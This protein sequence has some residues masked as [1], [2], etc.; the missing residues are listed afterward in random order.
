MN[1]TGPHSRVLIVGGGIGGLTTGIALARNGLGA[2]LLERS[3]FAD[4]TGAGIQLGPNATRALA[5]LGVLDA[6]ERVAFKPESLRLFD[7][8]TGSALA[9]MPLGRVVEDRHGAPY[10]TF[11]RADLHAALLNACRAGG[12]D[13]R[14]GLEVV[15]VESRVDGVTA[16]GAN[17]TT[18]EAACLVAA[19][20]LWSRLRA[21][22]APH[23]ELRFAGATAWRALLPRDGLPAPF[24]AAAV[25]LWLG[26]RAHLVHY[27][28][29]G[30]KELN[31]VAVVEGGSAE[32]G[33]NLRA[34][35]D[36]LAAAFN[37]WADPVKAVLAGVPAWR[38]WSLFRQTPLRS[39]TR[40]RMALL[41]D[42]AHPVLPYLAQGAALAIEDAVTVAACLKTEDPAS[43]FARYEAL[44]LHRAAR[45]QSQAARLGRLYHLGGF[46]A[47]T[48]NLILKQRRGEALL[49]GFDWLY[50]RQ[51]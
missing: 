6:V 43:A 39:W 26:P 36:A 51:A 40:G 2:T 5:G 27:P 23:A 15:D 41:G 50:G 45:V 10:L 48:R 46:A 18:I 3:A 12:V 9:V 8:A 30:G 14:D 47:V 16:R 22:I 31:L 32:Q 49:R 11:H 4:E 7:G 1:Q 38:C 33:W 34:E 44:R 20:G 13:L 28:V 42:A 35:P 21:E 24:D 17:G 29:R 37:R 19:D 25:G